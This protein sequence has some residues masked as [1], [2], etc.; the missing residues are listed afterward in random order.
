MGFH[1]RNTETRGKKIRRVVIR[2]GSGWKSITHGSRTAR[3]RL[4][5]REVHRIKKR[6]FIP[7]LFLDL[8]I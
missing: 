6:E 3:K 5:R 7:G 2:G 1:Y 8:G 4:T